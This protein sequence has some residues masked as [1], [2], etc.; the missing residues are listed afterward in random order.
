MVKLLEVIA[1]PADLTHEAFVKHQSTTHL[2]IVERVPEFVKPVR[3]YMQNHIFVDPGELP[4]VKGLPI[5]FNTDSIIEVW[6]DNIDAVTRAFQEPRY[7]EIIRPDEL[8]FGDV[9]GVWGVAADDV[10]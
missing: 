9:E 3:A 10:T 2:E 6:Y 1:R 4:F 7:F 5:S 8:A